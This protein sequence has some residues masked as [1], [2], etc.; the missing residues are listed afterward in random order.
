MHNARLVGCA[1]R[2][3]SLADPIEN[4]LAIERRRLRAGQL[5]QR[6]ALDELHRD[7]VMALVEIRVEDGDYVGM[8]QRGRDTRLALEAPDSLRGFRGEGQW[9]DLDRHAAI[10]AQVLS[11]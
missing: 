4:G 10:Q 11:F 9:Q 8:I 6:L 5:A 7:V 2:R 3:G 1:Q